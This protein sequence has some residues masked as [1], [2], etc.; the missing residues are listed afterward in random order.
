[1]LEEPR[2]D[3]LRRDVAD[4]KPTPGEFDDGRSTEP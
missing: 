1:M 4:R 3:V 2:T